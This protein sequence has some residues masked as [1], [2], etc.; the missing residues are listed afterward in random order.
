M[1]K[2]MTEGNL[3]TRKQGS[4]SAIFFHHKIPLLVPWEQTAVSRDTDPAT[5]H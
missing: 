2:Q 3:I 4:S 1:V 5:N